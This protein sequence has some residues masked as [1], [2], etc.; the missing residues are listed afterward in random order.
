[1]FKEK[2]N[3]IPPKVQFSNT[4]EIQLGP[5]AQWRILRNEISL[6]RR[7]VAHGIYQN[8]AKLLQKQL[9]TMFILFTTK[10]IYANLDIWTL[11]NRVIPR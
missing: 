6:Q 2:Q 3:G 9:G 4:L 11:Q 10:G 7:K 8:S 5:V 1:M